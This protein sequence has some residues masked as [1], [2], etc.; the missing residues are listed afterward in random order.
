[1]GSFM[2]RE[3]KV[4]RD[5]IQFESERGELPIPCRIDLGTFIYVP[6]KCQY[7]DGDRHPSQLKNGLAW[8]DA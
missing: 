5:K 1:M 4:R 2:A 6:D 3:N 7:G 8:G